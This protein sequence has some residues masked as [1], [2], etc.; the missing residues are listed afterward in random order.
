M[1]ISLDFELSW[2]RFDTIPIKVLDAES[3][4]TRT[5]IKRLL[6]LLDKYEIPTTW[7]TVGHLM[8]DGCARDRN[9]QAHSDVSPHACYSWFPADWYSFDPCTN[10]SSAPGW[11]APEVLE[12]IGGTRVRHEIGCHSFGH[13]V[14]GDPECTPAVARADLKAAVEAAAQK[15]IILSSFVFPRNLVG[16]LELLRVSGI[17]AFRGVNPYEVGPGLG[18][19]LKP[20]NFLKQLLGCSVKP[21]QPG[22]VLPGL[23]N[24]PANHFFMDRAGI[25]KILPRD[26]QAIK[27]MRSID[28]ATKSGGLYHMWFHPFNLNTDTDAMFYG[29]EQV[30][31]HAHRLREAGFLDIFTMGEYAQRLANQKSCAMPRQRTCH[32][33]PVA[34]L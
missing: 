14:Y 9:G 8:L 31:A 3:L 32:L 30:F 33:S 5:H 16:H 15:R 26:G 24:I 34:S 29:L 23:W 19:F 18:L 2:G 4:R 6:A 17:T 7:A 10:A 28:R 25:R 27:A 22:E 11:Y 20:L 12:W 21:V 13:I 1:V